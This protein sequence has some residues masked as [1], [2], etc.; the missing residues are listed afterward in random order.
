[1]SSQSPAV[2]PEVVPNPLSPGHPGPRHY[3]AQLRG[4]CS[5]DVVGGG[6]AVG[7]WPSEGDRSKDIPQQ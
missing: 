3:R 2:A 5:P 6:R 4:V 1:M 7:A